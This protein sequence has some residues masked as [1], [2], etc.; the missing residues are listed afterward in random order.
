MT[1]N[2]HQPTWQDARIIAQAESDLV[3]IDGT[4]MWG[5]ARIWYKVDAPHDLCVTYYAVAGET[6]YHL[7]LPAGHPLIGPIEEKYDGVIQTLR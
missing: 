3:V 6:E 5:I 1:N 4:D 2:Q 7:T